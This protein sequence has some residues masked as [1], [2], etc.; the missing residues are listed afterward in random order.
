M[1]H[2]LSLKT[3]LISGAVLAALLPAGMIGIVM[4]GS[5]HDSAIQEATARYELLAQSLASEHDRFLTAHRQAVQMLTREPDLGSP[6]MAAL[7]AQ[8]RASYPEFAAIAIV[9]SSGHVIMADPPPV[10]LEWL[11]AA[12][13][14]LS[15]RAWFQEILRSHLTVVHPEPEP[16]PIGASRPGVPIAV[17]ISDGR[18]ELEAVVAAWLRLDAIQSL[19]SRIRFG[20]TGFALLTTSEGTLLAHERP[21]HVLERRSLAQLPVWPVVRAR[22]SG[23]LPLYTGL[24]GDRRLAGFATVPGVG[25]KIWVT[26]ARTEI[27]ADLT[28]TYRRLLGWTLV[29]LLAT[30]ALAILVASYVSGPIAALRKTASAIAA[31]DATRTVPQ[32]GPQEVAGLAQAFQEMLGRLTRAQGALE[33]RLA[34]TAALLAIAKVV[35]GTLDLPEALRRICREL[36]H[37]TGAG[38]VA[39]HLVDPQRSRLDPVAAYHVPKALLP[40]L[41]ATPVPIAEQGFKDTVFTEGLIAWTDDVAHDPRFV[42]PLFQAVPHQSGAIVPLVLDGQVAGTLYLVWWTERRRFDEAELAI[43]QAV[44]RQAGTLLR[45]A[46]LHAATERHAQQATNLYEIAGQLASPVDRD[47]ILDRVAQGAVNLLRCDAAEVYT[48]DETRGGLVLRRG[49]HLDPSLRSDLVLRPG[50]G[51]AGLAFAERRPIWTG[52]READAAVEYWPAADALVRSKAPRACLAV[53]VGSG[54]AVHGV[55]ACY[56]LLPHAFTPAEVELFSILAVH[57]AIAL[58]RARL[59]H[60][61][62]S[63]RRDLGA[64]VT[65]TQRIT[66]GLDLHAVLH[67][68]AKAAAELFHGEAGFRLVQGELLVRAAVTPGAEEA[69]ATQRRRIGEGISGRVAATGKPIVTPDTTGDPR[70]PRDP[71]APARSDRTRA[72]MSVPVRIGARILGTLSVYR[73][74]GHRFEADAIALAGALADQAGIAI[75]NARLFAEAERRRQAAESFAEVGRI[76]SESL[77]P[78]EVADRIVESVRRLF[79]AQVASLYRVDVATGD[80]VALAWSGDMGPGWQAGVRLPAGTGA[81][82]VAVRDRRPVLSDDVFNDPRIPM[83]AEIRERLLVRSSL[84]A[85]AVPIVF[86]DRAIG[87]LSIGR[88]ERRSFQGDEVRMAQALASQAAL[89]LENSRVAAELRAAK[90]AAES[91]SRAK[92]EFVANMSHEIRTPMN[93]I[94]GMTELLLDTDLDPEQREYLSMVKSSADALLDIVNDVLDF[95]KVEAG[96]LDLDSADFSLRSTLSRALKP[97]AF[98]AHEKGVELAVD[99]SWG[100][101][102]PLV[103]DPGR[104]RQIVL[105]LVGNALKFTERGS[106]VVRVLPEGETADG[107]KLHFTVTDT[108]IGIPPDKQALIFEAFEQADTSSTRRHGGTGLGLA[109]T[110]RLVDMMGGQIWVE[111]VVGDG[112]VFHFTVCL[113]LGHPAEAPAPASAWRLR[114]VRVLVVDDHS[115]NRR[116]ILETLGHWGMA[117]TAVGSAQAALTAL[118]EARAAGA[119]FPL[120]L[121]DSEISDLDGF[122]LSERIKA[123]P[124]HAGTVLV[125]LSSAGR[126][127]DAARCRAAGIAGYLSTPVTRDE[128]LDVILTATSAPAGR[129]H[130][131]DL[132]TRHVLRERRDRLRILVCEDNAVNQRLTARIVERRGHVVVVV[133]TGQAALDALLRTRFDLVLM[134]LQMPDMDGLKAVKTI[135]DHEAGVAAG[136]WQPAAASSYA[137]G[138]IPVIAVTAHAMRG[139]RERG[140]AAGMDDYVTKPI[141][142]AALIAA[143]ER[144]CPRDGSAAVAPPPVD[145]TAARRVAGGDEGL[146][147]EVA[148]TFLES[149]PRQRTELAAAAKAAD[150]ARVAR[151]AHALKGAAGA[152]GA[153][154]AQELAAELEGLSRGDGADG[155]R[156]AALAQELD[157]ELGRTVEFLGTQTPAPRA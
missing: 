94:I 83:T 29:A 20:S 107:V 23:Q 22:D 82:G 57:A 77:D 100:T 136:H 117:A 131:P 116:I 2:R 66:R 101:P 75:E 78:R 97:L 3:I 10:A 111:S 71:Q 139:D 6:A 17:P 144:Q 15:A 7:L 19:T 120:V 54:D 24:L 40:I 109:I 13:V 156:L 9:D 151:I 129:G 45:S 33:S 105:N 55:L 115:I 52:D 59:F 28:A 85:L 21:D 130:A 26:Q 118:D 149:C 50:E 70:L 62:E 44:G 81:S 38:T 60:E 135:R 31:G 96:K 73:E 123:E 102:D 92:S 146:R 36:A 48:Y 64:L 34:E 110:R 150:W 79:D 125:M 18:G 39:V 143:I 53:P 56:F 14:D 68:I 99:V 89:A 113:G 127:G 61:S 27:E 41:T 128:L 69:M 119:P 37:L 153:T 30:L 112:S 122:A 51:I 157:Q 114:G 1:F 67:G 134:D 103:G 155:D 106:I 108:G 91:A 87:A 154:P 132:V 72:Q 43:L 4:V 47:Q 138:R 124:A 90:E 104:L 126:P 147:A 121:T 88:A 8:T 84:V 145:L 65:V 98:R 133:G 142:P 86:Q 58:E 74:R 12:P 16:S 93:G 152:V 32:G 148:A 35:G 49:L 95:S 140:L 63:R 141:Q 76:I 25:W 42:S 46:Q 5:L 80:L 11:A 137:A